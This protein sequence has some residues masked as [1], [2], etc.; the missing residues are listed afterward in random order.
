LWQ[1]SNV[2]RSFNKI[3]QIS[4]VWDFLPGNKDSWAYLVACPNNSFSWLPLIK[5]AGKLLV[6]L[7]HEAWSPEM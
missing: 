3:L 7:I 1:V 2:L 5:L 6:A 4:V